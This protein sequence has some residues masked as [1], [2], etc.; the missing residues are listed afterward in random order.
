[1]YWVGQK[2]L[3]LFENQVLAILQ[4]V[5]GYHVGERN[6]RPSPVAESSVAQQYFETHQNIKYLRDFVLFTAELPVSPHKD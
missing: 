2:V 3:K 4:V 5:G 6:Y 1:M